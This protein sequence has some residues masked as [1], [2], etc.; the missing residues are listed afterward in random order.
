MEVTHDCPCTDVC[1]FQLAC[2]GKYAA[3]LK[4]YGKCPG[5]FSVLDTRK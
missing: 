3:W 4:P 2:T 1:I 5:Q